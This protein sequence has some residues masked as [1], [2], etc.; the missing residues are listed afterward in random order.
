MLGRRPAGTKPVR[1]QSQT[2]VWVTPIR[3]ASFPTPP[4]LSIRVW[5]S[6]AAFVGPSDKEVNHLYVGGDQILS[7][8]PA[9]ESAIKCMVALMGDNRETLGQRLKALRDK[10]G[11]RAEDAA[12]AIGM[13][14]SHLSSIENEHDL[15]GR[16]TLFAIAKFYN[17]SIDY[18][19]AGSS[20]AALAPKG[21]EI[22]NDPDELAFLSFWRGLS[23]N[24]R[25]IMLKMLGS[26][27]SNDA[28]A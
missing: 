24:E 16:D 14:R 18:L 3:V 2:V 26:A 11:L 21:G 22:V 8:F 23:D 5:T 12:T 9:H 1:F 13:S 19:R 25:H 28:A 15:P 6:M 4:A 10:R 20:V 7:D 17:V 27:R